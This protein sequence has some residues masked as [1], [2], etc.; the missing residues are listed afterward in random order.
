[1]W[2]L[3][4]VRSPPESGLLIFRHE[5]RIL[6]RVFLRSAVLAKLSLAR[7]LQLH[8]CLSDR[9]TDTVPS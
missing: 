4:R 5:A 7:T 3:S 2:G 6:S 9:K 1:M 8:G